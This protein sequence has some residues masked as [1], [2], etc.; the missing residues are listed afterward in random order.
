MKSWIAS[1]K[2]SFPKS[3]YRFDSK[4]VAIYSTDAW[5]ASAAPE[6]V[7][8]PKNVREVSAIVKFAN[9]NKVPVTARGAGKGYVGGCVPVKGGIVLSLEKMNRILEIN[10]EDGIAVVEPGVIT[11]RLQAEV[12]KKGLFY[13]PD[14]ASLKDCFIGGNVAT[15]AGGPRCLKY[16]VT[17]NYILGLEVVLADGTIVNVGGRTMKNKTGF[18][19]VG[20]F[21]GSEGLLGIVTKITV[22]LI[23]H[24]QSRGAICAFFGSAVQA[25]KGVQLILEAGFLPATLEVAD[26][27]TLEA[28][29]KAM[30][31]SRIPP[32]DAYLLVETDGTEKAVR[33]D[34][35][36]IEKILF[37]LKPE[38][39]QKAFG[40]Q[41]TERLWELRRQFSG[42]LRATG[43]KKLNEDIVI[44]RSRLVDLFKLSEKIQKK[45][46]IPVASF[47]HAGD[48]NI[49][50]NLM[51]DPE[52]RKQKANADLAL[53]LLFK[54]VIAW[55]G[56]ITGEHGVGLAKMPWWSLAASPELRALH[57]TVKKALDPKGIL[58]PGKFV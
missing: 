35:K 38:R 18:D 29:R 16:G 28:V 42:S 49:H 55:N 58:N 37:D 3:L 27:L 24:P 1:F 4:T 17:R 47:G 52:D 57:R 43:M 12:K 41:A 20:I 19:L 22:R 26:R 13:P 44:P 21:V 40:D 5:L 23:P 46:G 15:N 9:Q 2:R 48:G 36:S 54:Q 53:D 56:A 39:V 34:L 6:M 32:S 30:G 7:C 8:F 14:P 25:A 11:G 51:L 45:Y 31:V 33:S 10:R 50:V